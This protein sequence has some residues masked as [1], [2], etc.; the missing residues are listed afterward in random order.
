MWLGRY[1]VVGVDDYYR[2]PHL[3]YELQGRAPLPGLP[4]AAEAVQVAKSSGEEQV[5]MTLALSEA[6]PADYERWLRDYVAARRLK[7]RVDLAMSTCT[8]TTPK[9]ILCVMGYFVPTYQNAGPLR[10]PSPR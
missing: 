1:P 3:V 5:R 6:A 10:R 9:G 8:A 7:R 2:T 4:G